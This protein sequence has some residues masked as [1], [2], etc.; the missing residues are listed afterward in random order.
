MDIKEYKLCQSVNLGSFPGICSLAIGYTYDELIAQYKEWDATGWMEAISKDKEL[1]DGSTWIAMVRV[2]ERPGEKDTYY[3]FIIIKE[4]FDFS[5]NAYT[6]LAHE[7]H[8]VVT[9]ALGDAL[10]LAREYEA[11]AYTH[12]HVMKQIL[13]AIRTVE[14]EAKK[15]EC[16]SSEPDRVTIYNNIALR[17]TLPNNFEY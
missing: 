2:V 7:V 15:R 16:A 4:W 1:I 13:E 3:Y 5:D 8:H 11:A 6:Y 10:N 12:T 17:R 14:E 9:F